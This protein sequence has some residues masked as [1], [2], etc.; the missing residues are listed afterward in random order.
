M[1]NRLLETKF[2]IPPWRAGGVTRPRLVDKL[3]AGL[4]ERRKLTLVSAPAGYGKTTL[5]VD[6]LSQ[7]SRPDRP[8][9]AA[10]SQ[11]QVAWL[12]LDEA[13]NDPAHFL[14]YWLSALRRAND[15]LGQ[16]AQSLLGMPQIPPLAE[17]L[18][19]LINDLAAQET[20]H[21]SGAG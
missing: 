19:E 15:T 13:D 11:V 10:H 1:R 21:H 7:T 17:I 6:W 2:H 12:S 14:G 4:K 3:H 16:S 18:D 20:S 8:S 9:G 5:V